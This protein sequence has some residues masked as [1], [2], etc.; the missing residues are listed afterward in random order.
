MSPV[1][2]TGRVG[3]I[4]MADDLMYFKRQT[5]RIAVELRVLFMGKD[6]AVLISGGDR[7]HLGAAALGVPR[8]SL[9]N[10]ERWSASVSV[11]T[12]TGH[13]D[14]DLARLAAHRLAAALKVSVV[15]ACGI[16]VDNLTAEELTAIETTIDAMLGD[17]EKTLGTG[18]RE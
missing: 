10:H 5:G 2:N 9:Q 13:R 15:V 14:D 4:S 17:C 7:P 1:F 16:H 3:K 6:L 18:G 11:I 12:L 8:P